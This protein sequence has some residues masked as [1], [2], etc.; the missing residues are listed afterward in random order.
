MSIY[1]P[2]A[3]ALSAGLAGAGATPHYLAQFPDFGLLDV[4]I[5]PGFTD[6]SWFKNSCPSFEL[7]GPDNYASGWP[8]LTIF[9]DYADS[10]LRAEPGDVRFH[11]Y[12]GA[13]SDQADFR[14]DDWA[15]V[16]SFVALQQQGAD[17]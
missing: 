7:A 6:E 13:V 8:L 5:P 10:G 17:S 1:K 14:S 9:I 15:E 16:L 11:V 2:T 3:C 12:I 4:E